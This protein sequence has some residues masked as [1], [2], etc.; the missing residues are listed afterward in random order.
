MHFN[1]FIGCRAGT[2]GGLE[3]AIAPLLEQASTP[4]EGEKL[5]FGDF[6][7]LQYPESC[8]LAPSL[9]ESAPCQK[10]PGATPDWV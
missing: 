2:R 6:W 3:G 7:H 10:I 4:S 8:I 1:L 5:F 9:E